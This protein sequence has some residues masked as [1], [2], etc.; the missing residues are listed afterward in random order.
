MMKLAAGL[1]KSK[2][3]LSDWLNSEKQGNT[4]KIFILYFHGYP[5]G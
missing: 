3:L 1:I 4:L 2:S 5:R